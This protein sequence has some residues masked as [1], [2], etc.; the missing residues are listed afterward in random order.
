M[1]NKTT[2]RL[3]Y[4]KDVDLTWL[5]ENE[6]Y[7]TMPTFILNGDDDPYQGSIDEH[8]TIEDQY[9]VLM[10]MPK[11]NQVDTPKKRRQ[12]WDMYD[13]AVGG[14]LQARQVEING[15]K[16]H[17]CV[18]DWTSAYTNYI[19]KENRNKNKNE[20][21]DNKDD[22]LDATFI[23]GS[24]TDPYKGNYEKHPK[25]KDQHD[26]LYYMEKV[27]IIDTQQKRKEFWEMYRPDEKNGD[28]MLREKEDRRTNVQKD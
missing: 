11:I 27:N 16:L 26:K 23:L 7:K 6:S 4:G 15:V 1:D 3:S 18:M 19:E 5:V 24:E 17:E 13:I 8:P 28:I 14:R 20:T 22:E 9:K 12:F 10:E 21:K 2:K 25:I